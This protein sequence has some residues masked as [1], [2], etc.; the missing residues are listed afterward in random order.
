MK[1]RFL[2]IQTVCLKTL[3][4]CSL[5]KP[6]YKALNTPC[7]AAAFTLVFMVKNLPPIYIGM[8]IQ[9]SEPFIKIKFALQCVVHMQKPINFI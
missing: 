2:K 7:H 6:V 4:T 8:K 3:Q 1:Y 9:I 5:E